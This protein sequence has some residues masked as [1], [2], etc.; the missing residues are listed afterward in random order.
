MASNKRPRN[1][2]LLPGG[3]IWRKPW[4]EEAAWFAANP[5]VS[6]FVAEDNRVVL[7]EN[8]QLRP[9]QLRTVLVNEAVRAYLRRR[10]CFLPMTFLTP[11]QRRRFAAYGRPVYCAHTVIA[12]IV[13]GDPSGGCPTTQQRRLARTL[14]KL[15]KMD[16]YHRSRRAALHHLFAMARARRVKVVGST[17]HKLSS[18]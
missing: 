11:F 13:A 10:G 7:N 14:R 8:T 9:R 16:I 2:G 15:M 1:L 4:A 12:R 18:S 6:G 5:Q 17:V 3:A